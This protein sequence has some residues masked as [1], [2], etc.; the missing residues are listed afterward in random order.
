MYVF[1]I[2][3]TTQNSKRRGPRPLRLDSALCYLGMD[4]LKVLLDGK[5]P[6]RG[7][8]PKVLKLKGTGNFGQLAF[9][10]FDLISVP[11]G[12]TPTERRAASIALVHAAV[13][14]GSI[15]LQKPYARHLSCRLSSEILSRACADPPRRIGKPL[16][17]T[18]PTFLLFILRVLT[19]SETPPRSKH[20]AGTKV[21]QAKAPKGSCG[22]SAR[23]VLP[24][25][26]RW[27]VRLNC[28]C[29]RRTCFPP[30]DVLP[31]FLYEGL[32][33]ILA[34]H[35]A[36]VKGVGRR[37]S[38]QTNFRLPAGFANRMAVSGSLSF[39]LLACT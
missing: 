7:N 29:N 9:P 8:K 39:L 14:Q 15:I 22:K 37:T 12:T 4:R 13:K 6:G 23:M 2:K 33:G 11:L 21:K 17:R 26:G 38:P 25:V 3:L 10:G 18:P 5:R 27:R 20:P 19:L 34:R 35:L 24:A 36:A 30:C 1:R 28:H 32:L 31:L 16:R